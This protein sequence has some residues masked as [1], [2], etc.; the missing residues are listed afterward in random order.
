VRAEDVTLFLLEPTS[1]TAAHSVSIL[2]VSALS[3]DEAGATHYV[4]SQLVSRKET[5]LTENPVMTATGGCISCFV[6]IR[7]SL[8]QT[9]H[10]LHTATFQADATRLLQQQTISGPGD[11]VIKTKYEC[12]RL[13][14]GT[15][16]CRNEVAVLDKEGV[17]ST[18]FDDT[19]TGTPSPWWTIK[20]VETGLPSDDR[21]GAE[22]AQWARARTCA[23]LASLAVGAA[24]V[25]V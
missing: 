5:Y 7:F 18:R 12:V 1:N 20:N 21:G 11:M 8:L 23:V 17:T 25:L 10:P 13:E 19:Q 6:S 4:Y 15:L 9:I 2:G 22:S 24:L 16:T 14:N 3:V